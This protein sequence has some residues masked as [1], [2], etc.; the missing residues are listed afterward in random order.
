MSSTSQ[1]A[2]ADG[3]LKHWSAG[4]TNTTQK[5]CSEQDHCLRS[6]EKTAQGE[7]QDELLSKRRVLWQWTREEFAKGSW[8]EL[9]LYSEQELL[10]SA[11][12]FSR[13]NLTVRRHS[14]GAHGPF[15]HLSSSE[16]L[17]E[18]ITF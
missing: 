17:K 13:D 15:T 11:D 14:V 9:A 8:C 12:F 4:F 1:Y 18:H 10:H 7:Q 5:T 6:R 3:S 16:Q 2:V